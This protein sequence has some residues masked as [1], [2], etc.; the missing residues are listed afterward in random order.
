MAINKTVPIK[1]NI[2]SLSVRKDNE[3]FPSSKYQIT[4]E[5]MREIMISITGNMRQQYLFF[6]ILYKYLIDIKT[7]K[8]SNFLLLQ[9]ISYRNLMLKNTP[10]RRLKYLNLD[11]PALLIRGCY[12]PPPGKF[13]NIRMHLYLAKSIE[14]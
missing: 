10:E 2:S 11:L 12:S 7:E 8:S 14:Y 9:M 5:M 13:Q 1:L 4:S 6:S 3:R